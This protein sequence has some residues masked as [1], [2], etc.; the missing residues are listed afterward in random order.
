MW[1]KKNRVV[2]LGVS[3]KQKCD[4]FISF[5]LF[6]LYTGVLFD[7]SGSYQSSMIMCGVSTI[8]VGLVIILIRIAIHWQKNTR[9]AESSVSSKIHY[10]TLSNDVK[11]T[12]V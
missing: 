8:S 9:T 10:V 2:L 3:V 7:K 6:I 5:I 12:H 11:S 4:D 1:K